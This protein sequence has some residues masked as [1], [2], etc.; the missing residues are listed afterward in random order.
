MSIRP[1]NRE[2]S[3]PNCSATTNGWWLGSITPPVPTLMVEVAAATAAAST[4]GAE[5]ATPGTLWCSD[6][7]KRW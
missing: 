6:T 1:G 3:T 7:Q 4:V 2:A 5:P